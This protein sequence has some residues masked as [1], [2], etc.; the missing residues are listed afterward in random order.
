MTE[1]GICT[2]KGQSPCPGPVA[3]HM[4]QSWLAMWSRLIYAAA[5]SRRISTE[6]PGKHL[7]LALRPEEYIFILHLAMDWTCGNSWLERMKPTRGNRA[8]S[9]WEERDSGWR[10]ER[11][12]FDEVWVPGSRYFWRQTYPLLLHG[13]ALWALTKTVFIRSVWFSVLFVCSKKKKKKLYQ[14]SS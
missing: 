14:L 13:S 8:G 10:V 7:S 9:L 3:Y 1:W 4:I 5:F 6:A 12:K 2:R 11:E